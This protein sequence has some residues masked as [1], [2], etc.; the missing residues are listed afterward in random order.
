MS[1]Q[2]AD[3]K[4]LAC[5]SGKHIWLDSV[6]RTLCCDPDYVAVADTTRQGL[7]DVGAVG[8]R[9]AQLWRGWVKKGV[10]T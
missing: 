6:C 3:R 1:L 4:R 7:E 10:E 9:F 2:P 5:C 8:V